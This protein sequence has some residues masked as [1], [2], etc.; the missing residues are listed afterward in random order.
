[1]TQSAPGK[2]YRKG[3]T[4]MQAS[5]EFSDEAKSEQFCLDTRW[6]DGVVCP[7]C[8]SSNVAA[9]P[10]RK[11]APFRCRSCRKDFSVKTGTIMEGSKLSLGTWLFAMYLM[12]TS[13]RG[14]SSMKLH[15]DLGVTQKTAWFL[16]HRIRKAWET[17]TG[18][19]GGPVEVDE[20][21]VGGR[22]ANKHKSKRLNAGRGVVGKTAVVGVKDRETNQIVSA[23]VPSTD[24]DTLQGFVQQHTAEA[25][26]IITDDHASYHGLPNHEVVRH[27]AGEYVR[28]GG[29]STNGMESHWATLKRSIMG[30]YFHI[31]P[32]HTGRYA[33]EVSGRHNNRPLDTVEQVRSLV[34]NGEGKRL[35]YQDLVK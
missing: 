11:P 10:S 2:Y 8:Q 20:T 16:E 34:Q 25:A 24:R 6:P 35:R 9:R 30:S 15:R 21:Y 14:V 4:L 19:F 5:R 13:L 7:F 32:K 29:I 12:S 3:M 17:E 28:D 31:S 27:G 22:E 23:A 33:T 18:L 1:M 26:T